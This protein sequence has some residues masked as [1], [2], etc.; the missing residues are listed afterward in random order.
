MAAAP[1]APA[2]LTAAEQKQWLAG[3]LRANVEREFRAQARDY[4]EEVLGMS[5][6]ERLAIFGDPVAPPSKWE[7]LNFV[8]AHNVTLQESRTAIGSYSFPLRWTW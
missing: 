4:S 7:R 8:V 1:A 6:I 3:T 5:D 2:G